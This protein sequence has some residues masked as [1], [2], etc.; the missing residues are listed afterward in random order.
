M[1]FGSSAIAQSS[2]L[3]P[4]EG[5]THS[6][7]WSGLQQG[8]EYEFYIT[9]DADGNG[10]YDDELNG[11]FDFLSGSSGTVGVGGSS[12]LVDVMW[13]TGAAGGDYFMWL[14]VTEPG[15]C[16]NYR[17]VGIV[18]QPN[19]RTIGFD[20]LA[21]TGCFDVES[22]DFSLPFNAQDGSGQPLSAAN[23]P[24]LIEFNV[25]GESHSQLV[26]FENQLLQISETMF[27][28]NP[29][30]NTVV[31]VEITSALDA[32]SE[33]LVPEVENGT[34]VRTLFAI[35][36]IEFTEELRIKYNLYEEITAYIN[37][38]PDRNWRME[39]K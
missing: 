17:Y 30:Q 35:P 27:A 15:G 8:A 32:N 10:L 1:A 9:A 39:P 38:N 28:A 37:G 5:A 23:F 14:K 33:V 3:S 4:Y 6:Y 29:I 18:P 2:A 7:S 25:N 12:A 26:S 31:I 16:S 24:M 21:S 19:D 13:N 36:E 20:V 11:E 22:N 34:H